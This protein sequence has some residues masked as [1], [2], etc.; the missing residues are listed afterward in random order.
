MRRCAR[1]YIGN[2]RLGDQ[3]TLV[4]CFREIDIYN[5][6]FV[7]SDSSYSDT[8]TPT[9]IVLAAMDSKTASVCVFIDVSDPMSLASQAECQGRRED[10]M[11]WLPP[12]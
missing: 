3:A 2:S 10:E 11:L 6:P 9:S 12:H 5:S 4:L 8:G 1:S 7:F